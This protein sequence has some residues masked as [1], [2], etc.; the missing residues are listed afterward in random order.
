MRAQVVGIWSSLLVL[1]FVAACGSSSGPSCGS[2]TRLVGGACVA[3]GKGPSCG[4][5]T[6]QSGTTCVPLKEDASADSDAGADAGPDTGP[7]AAADAAVDASTDAADVPSNPDVC[8]PTCAPTETCMGGVCEPLPIPVAWNCAKT[9]FADGQTCDCG[10][11]AV[12]PDCAD[13]L[14]P[15]IGCKSSGACLP[16]GACP[17]CTPGCAGKAC[18]DDGCGGS[19]GACA[20]PAKPSCVAGACAACVPSCTGKACGDD[21][22]GGTCGTCGEGQLCAVDQCAYPSVAQSCQ[23]HCGGLAPSGCACTPGC[24]GD[25]SC[26][27]DVGLCGCVP[28][29]SS[30]TCGDDGCGSSC[31]ACGAG[32]VCASGQCQIVGACDNGM[33]NGHG[34]CNAAGT[35]CVCQTGYA[36]AFCDA[37]TAGLIGYPTC[38]PPCQDVTQCDDASACTLDVCSLASGCLHIAV[39]CD[40]AN[41]C[42]VDS[43]TASTGCSYLPSAATPC[44]DGDACTGTGTCSAGTCIGGAAINCDDGNACSLDTCDPKAGCL[45]SNTDA[46][47]DDGDV[48]STVSVCVNLT[49]TSLGGVNCDDGN[50]CT[51]DLCASQTGTCSHPPATAGVPCDDEDLCTASDSCDGKGGCMAGAKV[52]ALTVT[53]GLIA[54]YSAAQA[55]SLIYGEDKAVQ[56]WQDDSGK[57]HDLSAVDGAKAPIFEA[58]AIHGRHGVRMSGAAGLQSAAFGSSSAISVFAVICSDVSGGPGT[59]AAQGGAG[60]WHLGG[61]S[62]NLAW[63]VGGTALVT[64][65]P[66]STC[67]VVAARAGGSKTDFTVIDAVSNAKS[68]TATWTP[69]SQPLVVGTEG[70][71]VLLGELLVYD[72]ALTDGE[73]DSVATYLRMA[74][75]FDPP[76]PDLVWYDATDAASV[77]RDAQGLVTAW[78]D[79]SGLGHHALVGTANSPQWFASGTSNSQAAVRF[80]GATVRLQTAALAASAN[81][82]VFAV[83]EMDQPQAWGTVLAHGAGAAFVLRKTDSAT[84]QW[85]TA[86]NPAAPAL[87]FVAGQWQ[88]VTALQ[89]GTQSALYTGAAA[90]QS[91]QGPE[92]G[93]SSASLGLGN[94]LAGGASMGGFIAEIRA[95]ASALAA[96]DRAFIEHLLHLK[97]GL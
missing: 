19:C 72:H 28:D 66:P 24:S 81:V 55:N 83:L 27:V 96:T 90:V 7:D 23:G 51:Q 13:A 15:V 48:C 26:C 86:A 20:D 58:Q 30:K 5:G 94:S 12:D 18:G 17:V 37:C 42:T 54:H 10:C 61:S 77:Q 49:C 50:P 56:T 52:C 82:T 84:L 6:V 43:C 32:S 68:G 64:Q 11:G 85:Q 39:S 40:D 36:G 53:S 97:Y 22:C 88:L 33:C 9:A 80:D 91:A 16:S 79:K 21:G 67:R 71:A 45:H 78:L 87:P 3:T 46:P 35:A 76:Q 34:Q 8:T 31:G 29:C 44:E 62:N 47:C 92:I 89:D 60:G 93:A 59:L 14:R 25:G 65:V 73:R 1:A 57:G 63:T 38:V 74:W 69:G 2:G 95:Y 75:G 4:A 41:L 70:A